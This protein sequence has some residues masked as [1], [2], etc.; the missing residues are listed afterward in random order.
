MPHTKNQISSEGLQR[1][2]GPPVG[3]KSYMSTM[4]MALTM[5]T[6]DPTLLSGNL[7][8]VSDDIPEF[9]PLNIPKGTIISPWWQ[10]VSNT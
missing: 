10:T 2:C 1:T 3:T 4:Y 6:R 9:D 5:S 8:S 7:T